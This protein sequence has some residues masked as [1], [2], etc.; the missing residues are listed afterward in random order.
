[1]QQRR[2]ARTIVL[3]AFPKRKAERLRLDV[4][5]RLVSRIAVASRALARTPGTRPK[6]SDVGAGETPSDSAGGCGSV[7]AEAEVFE[8]VQRGISLGAV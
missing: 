8:F 7:E 1:M 3:Q 4:W 6:R 2:G 5:R